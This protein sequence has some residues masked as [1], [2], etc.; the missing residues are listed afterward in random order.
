[1]DVKDGKEPVTEHIQMLGVRFFFVEQEYGVPSVPTLSN[2]NNIFL[3]DA[4][5]NFVN[6]WFVP[7]VTSWLL[8]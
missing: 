8:H 7:G 5:F 3:D 6:K 1:M 4:V 2:D